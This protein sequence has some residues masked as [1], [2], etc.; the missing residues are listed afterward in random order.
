[1]ES[2]APKSEFRLE[3]ERIVADR[4]LANHPMYRAWAD[5]SLSRRCMAGCMAESYHY[6][7]NVYP[8]FF[9]IA[10]KAPDDVIRMEIENYS[11]EMNP[12]NPHPALFLRFIEACGSDAESVRRSR[13]LP[14]T[15]YWVDWL[16]K[17][18]KEEPW[19][20]AVA[21]VHVGSEFQGVGT[22]KSI[23]PALRNKYKF[24]EYEIEHFWLHAEVDVQ[25]SGTAFD[26]LERHC[27]SRSDQEMVKHFVAESVRRRWFF[28]DCVYLHYEKGELR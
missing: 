28:M 4:Y 8:V 6:V 24:T 20:A 13:G 3:L 18:A 22:F 1:M 12:A 21:A 16:M 5:G 27:T 23:L 14:S 2:T 9:L 17:L 25:H 7:S 19:Q 10:A 26:V 15:E 11:D